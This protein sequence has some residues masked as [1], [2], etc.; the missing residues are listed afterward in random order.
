[1]NYEQDMYIDHDSLDVEWLEQPRLMMKY[2]ELLADAEK[3]VARLEEKLS[4]ITSGLDLKIR[5]DPE[6]YGIEK[7][8]ESAVRSTIAFSE[9]IEKQKKELLEAKYEKKMCQGAVNSV[10]QRKHALEGMSKLLGLQYFAGPRVPRDLNDAV[11]NK[12]RQ[13]RVDSKVKIKRRRNS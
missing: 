3:E 12:N 4:S 13:E 11:A 5:A 10:E 6:S 2:S 8:T 9:V 7:L 1:M